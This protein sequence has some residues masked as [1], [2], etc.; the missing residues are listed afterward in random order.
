MIFRQPELGGEIWI[1]EPD[2]GKFCC[3]CCCEAQGQVAD[4]PSILGVIQLNT[5][6]LNI[7]LLI[8]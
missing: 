7:F 8:N 5:A 3:C 1:S 2:L 6:G 4:I